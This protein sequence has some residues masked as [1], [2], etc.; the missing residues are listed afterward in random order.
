LEKNLDFNSLRE[1][2]KNILENDKKDI[3]WVNKFEKNFKDKLNSKYAIAVN[4]GTSGLH[5][6]LLAAGVG[7]G[8]EVLQPSITVVMDSYVT[9]HVG[10]KPVF[11][12]VDRETWNIDLDKLENAITAKTKAIITVSLYGLPLQMDKLMKL[13]RKHNLIV[14]DDS[15]ETFLA[16]YNGSLYSNLADITVYSFERTKHMTSGSEGG[17]VTTN[18]SYLAEKVRKFAGIGYK[19]LVADAGRT[20]LSSEVYQDPNYERFDT[21]GFNYRM[22]AITAACGIAQLDVLEELVKL[23]QK[24]GLAFLSAIKDCSWMI[25][26]K[27]SPNLTHTYFTFGIVYEGEEKRNIKWKEFYNMY[28]ERDGDGFYA[29]WKNPYLEPSLKNKNFGTQSWN[30]GLCPNAEELQKKIM[31]FKTNY[32]DYEKAKYKINILSDLIDDIGR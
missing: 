2:M 31:A 13:A 15:A 7:E 21:I 10:A 17:M 24:I 12:D 1:L 3:S 14:I 16:E 6:A 27:V 19:G 9:L 23:R 4:S 22:N 30:E 11:V 29:C 5:A 32:K 26:Q 8:D 28:K 25:P 20:S 18:N